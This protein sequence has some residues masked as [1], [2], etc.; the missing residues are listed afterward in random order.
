MSNLF[1]RA[2]FGID[3]ACNKFDILFG[4]QD[5]Q[6]EFH[7]GSEPRIYENNPSNIKR[8]ISWCK[9]KI[10]EATKKYPGLFVQVAVEATGVYHEL[11]VEKA[12]DAGL[13]VCLVM[14]KSV[15]HYRLSKN[16]YSKNDRQDARL[17]AMLGCERRLNPWEPLSP[18]LKQ[19]RSILRHRSAI[20]KM[21]TMLKNQSHAYTRSSGQSRVLNQC[22]KEQKTQFKKQIKKLETEAKALMDHDKEL[23]NRISPIIKT[24]P[25]IG[26][27]TAL[28]VIAETNGFSEQSSA[29]QLAS[30]AGLDVI[31]NQS[32][33]STGKTRMSKRGNAYLRTCLYMSATNRRQKKA[34][35]PIAEFGRRIAARNP[36]ATKKATVGIMRKLL[37]LIR[38]LWNSGLDYD[39][40][41]EENKKAK[42]TVVMESLN[43]VSKTNSQ[44]E[45]E[46][47]LEDEK[48]TN[49]SFTLSEDQPKTE[50]TSGQG[51]K[52][53]S[54][55]TGAS[56]LREVASR[57][58]TPQNLK[59]RKKISKMLAD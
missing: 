46:P 8:C 42:Q 33:K 47:K 45:K 44:K 38:T 29:K 49:S 10:K 12:H 19:I 39:P 13:N 48:R 17:I 58:G 43:E 21:Q 26:W 52:K 11:F 9:Q 37:L 6:G 25:G 57:K 3:M 15:H 4:L 30:Y 16:R 36:V 1:K 35:G 23:S 7:N 53:D 50:S 5:E 28:T 56:R 20:V 32:G 22:L 27:L 31:E 40:N 18:N 41:Y 2:A 59:S 54:P 14:P 34:T 24:V 55:D 51:V